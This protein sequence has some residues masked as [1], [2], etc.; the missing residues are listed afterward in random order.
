MAATGIEYREEHRLKFTIAKKTILVGTMVSGLAKTINFAKPIIDEA[1]KASSAASIA[2]VGV[3]LVLPLI[4]RPAEAD[5][6]STENIAR[7]SAMMGF[8]TSIEVEYLDRGREATSARQHLEDKVC[9]LYTAILDYLC[10]SVLRFYARGVKRVWDDIL[11]SQDW[12]ALYRK[13]TDAETSLQ[14]M[15]ATIA[16]LLEQ[17]AQ[18]AALQI[19]ADLLENSQKRT[20]IAEQQLSAQQAI[21]ATGKEQLQ[22]AKR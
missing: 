11:Q 7:L 2:W 10:R 3:S 8:Y 9:E 13:V 6:K 22:L 17:Q 20:R 14:H 18:K 12:D 1:V 4:T 5:A 15:S 21:M 16:G 19:A